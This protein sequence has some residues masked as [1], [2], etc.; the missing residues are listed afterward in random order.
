MQ[1]NEIHKDWQ[2]GSVEKLLNRRDDYKF[3]LVNFPL[4]CCNIPTARV[5]EIYIL[6]VDT[7]P[8]SKACGSYPDFLAKGLML[9]RK[10]LKW[11]S[12]SHYFE[13]FMLAIMTWL[14]IRAYLYQLLNIRAYLY[15]LLN[16]RA[17]LYQLLNIRAYLYQLLQRISCL[18]RSLI[19][20]LIFCLREITGFITRIIRR[21]PLVEEEGHTRQEHQSP[22]VVSMVCVAQYFGLCVFLSFCFWSLYYLSVELRLLISPF[23]ISTL[24]AAI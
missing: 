24:V 8:Y 9:T 23:F 14:N 3:P 18:F 4:K 7:V 1:I 12:W 19:S 13:R 11:L 10:L 5:Y 20:V 21:K 16:I 22:P 2:W 17:Y 6:S 15:Q